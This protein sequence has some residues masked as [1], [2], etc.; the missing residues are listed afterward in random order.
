LIIVKENYSLNTILVLNGKCCKYISLLIRE[1]ALSHVIDLN[2]IYIC[3]IYILY[4]IEKHFY[5]GVP[6]KI[7][8]IFKHRYNDLDKKIYKLEYINITFIIYK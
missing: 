4:N 3:I 2:S 5:C 7:K 6:I 8:N 1:F